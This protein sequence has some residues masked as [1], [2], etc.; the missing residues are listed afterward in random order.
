MKLT[1]EAALLPT[2][3]LAPFVGTL[4]LFFASLSPEAQAAWN[5]AATAVAGFITAALVVHD[6]LAPAILGLAQAVVN[7]LAVYGFGLTAAQSTGVMAFLALVVG[8]YVRT[9]VTAR[10]TVDG[11]V[12]YSRPV[13]APAQP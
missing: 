4:L 13:D 10:T 3:L 11:Q 9:Q 5:A 7:I 2:S 8:A 6:R 1:R 12:L